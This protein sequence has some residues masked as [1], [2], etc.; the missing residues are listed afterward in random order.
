MWYWFLEKE[1]SPWYRDV[2]V[3]RQP[4]QEH[5]WATLISAS[6]AEISDF[7]LTMKSDFQ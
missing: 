5:S 4:D 6:A 1:Q 2:K 3:R 7:I